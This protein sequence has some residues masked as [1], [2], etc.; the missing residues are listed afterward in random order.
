M[1]ADKKYCHL[2]F[3]LDRTLWDF[4]SSSEEALEKLYKQHDLYSLGIPSFDLFHDVYKDVNLELWAQYRNGRVDKPT[5]SLN[6]F[7]MTFKE[8]GMDDVNLAELISRE[9]VHEVS[10]NTELFPEVHETLGYL[11]GKYRMHVITNGFVEVQYRKI[12]KSGLRKYFDQIITSEESGC[13]KP[14]I[15]IFVLALER[16]GAKAEESLMIGDDPVVDLL[17]A[18]LAGMDQLYVN[19]Y[20]QDITGDFTYAV[21]SLSQIKNIL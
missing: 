9:Y 6:R 8:F 3:D 7:Y 12:E 13:H 19:H 11:S 5:L 18:R 4:D 15:E 17:G 16:A 20:G 10:E 2:F 1:S 14:A 21:N